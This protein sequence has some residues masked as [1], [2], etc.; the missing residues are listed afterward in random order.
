MYSLLIR[1]GGSL[2]LKLGAVRSIIEPRA[3]RLPGQSL[4]RPAEALLCI[5]GIYFRTPVGDRTM[6][7]VKIRTAHGNKS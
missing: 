7:R 6:E 1:E 3:H 2:G 5:A 4:D